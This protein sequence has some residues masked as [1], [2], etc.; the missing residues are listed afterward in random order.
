LIVVSHA[1]SL[2]DA[3][4]EAAQCKRLHL[5]KTFGETVLS[6]SNLFNKPRWQW[7]PR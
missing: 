3:L 4:G 5:E 1:G 2:I 6:E 7:P